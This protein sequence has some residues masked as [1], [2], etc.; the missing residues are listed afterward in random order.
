[1]HTT[2]TQYPT[3]VSHKRNLVT[4]PK[5]EETPETDDDPVEQVTA[6][7]ATTA[8]DSHTPEADAPAEDPESWA[9]KVGSCTEC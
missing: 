6:E 7:P 4:S 1:M 2:Q 5:H 9:D 3:Q 8:V